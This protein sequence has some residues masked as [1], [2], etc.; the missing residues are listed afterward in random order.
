MAFEALVAHLYQINLRND[1]AVRVVQL[2]RV[3]SFEMS[4]P[5]IANL[6]TCIV[7][8]DVGSTRTK[9]GLVIMLQSKRCSFSH[10][11]KF[12]DIIARVAVG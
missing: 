6:K 1:H 9:P 7:D 4:W 11:G 10:V 3:L 5:Y 12:R 8:N 2:W